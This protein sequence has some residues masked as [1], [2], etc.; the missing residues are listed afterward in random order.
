MRE[1]IGKLKPC[2]PMTPYT[3]IEKEVKYISK[4][5]T[6]KPISYA[7]RNILAARPNNAAFGWKYR[8]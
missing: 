3:P 4:S 1:I 5:S 7:K 6:P 2:T 8:D